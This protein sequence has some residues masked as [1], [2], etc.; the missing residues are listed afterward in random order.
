MD[1]VRGRGGSGGHFFVTEELSRGGRGRPAEGM[2]MWMKGGLTA[3]WRLDRQTDWIGWKKSGK[4]GRTEEAEKR[5]ERQTLKIWHSQAEK[6]K[7][8][9]HTQ[10]R[11]RLRSRQN[12][13]IPWQ[14]V[15]SQEQRKRCGRVWRWLAASCEWR[16]RSAKEM[17]KRGEGCL[18]VQNF[19]ESEKVCGWK[20]T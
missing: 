10:K 5:M 19:K 20:I 15:V 8:G 11:K 13:R 4:E 9:I 6:N 7:N 2:W 16:Q 17:D 12:E 18:V 1:R 14:M 3:S